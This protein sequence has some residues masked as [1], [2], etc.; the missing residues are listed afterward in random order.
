[1][2]DGNN[3]NG[4]NGGA[5]GGGGGAVAAADA[6]VRIA[7]I[8]D[9]HCTR[10]SR[11]AYQKILDQIAESADVLVI[12]GDLTD[13]G[14]PEEA[15]VLAK[16]LSV[17]AKLPTVAVLGNHDLESGREQDVCR[18][19]GDAGVTILDGDAKEI[20]GIGFAGVK[21]F[22]GGFGRATLSAFGEPAIKDFV[23]E[24]LNEV[25]KLETALQRLQTTQR[26][27]VLHYAPTRETVEG[28]PPEIFPFL[29]S[30]R[31]EEPL[32]RYQVTVAVHGHAH[33]G[34]PEG[35]TSVGIPVYNVSM[36][37]MKAAFPD[38]PAF[39]LLEMHVAKK[40]LPPHRVPV[41]T[42]VS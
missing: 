9:L 3:K 16:E 15:E 7:A 38:R 12:C 19:L 32:N 10:A 40:A 6:V 30:S 41:A 39:R 8:S 25:M 23:K 18:I 27:A 28:E 22:C 42:E 37:V 13:H 2:P 24:S 34:A 4:R 31:L 14:L 20:R 36:P 21:G 5:G 33:K 17:A 1:M 11:G 35:H 26:V 29:G